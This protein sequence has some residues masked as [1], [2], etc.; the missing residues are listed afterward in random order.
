MLTH[1]C[2]CGSGAFTV[3]LLSPSLQCFA[4][5]QA[6]S[7]NTQP[8]ADAAK[9]DSA[10]A[11]A[12]EG[13]LCAAAEPTDV[14]P[15]CTCCAPSAQILGPQPAYASD[16]AS[17]QALAQQSAPCSGFDHDAQPPGQQSC[18]ATGALQQ[19]ARS[20]RGAA[21][22]LA[23]ARTI[24]TPLA[25]LWC[26]YAVTL[27]IFPGFLAEDVSDAALGS[28]YPVLL[29][30]VFASTDCASRWLPAPRRSALIASAARCVGALI[31]LLAC[32]YACCGCIRRASSLQHVSAHARTTARVLFAHLLHEPQHMKSQLAAALCVDA[33][34]DRCMAQS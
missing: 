1:A 25:A 29:F 3:N 26:V 19:P 30:L 18:V 14:T 16:H 12:V 34:H 22:W 9:A 24:R 27:S 4:L 11:L 20:Q 10:Q 33:G 2:D 28:W 7:A 21:E 32:S 13:S 15:P 31:Q 5:L 8:E 6:E 17:A 23:V